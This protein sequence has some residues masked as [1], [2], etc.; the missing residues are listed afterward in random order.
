MRELANQ[1]DRRDVLWRENAN[2][3]KPWTAYDETRPIEATTI[4]GLSES[5]WLNFASLV[6]R[7][8]LVQLKCHELIQCHICRSVTS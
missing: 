3:M 6:P 5:K 7:R 2:Q 8:F 1:L 4:Q